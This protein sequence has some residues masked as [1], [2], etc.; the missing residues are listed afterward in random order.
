VIGVVLV[1][2]RS[3]TRKDSG[4]HSAEQAAESLPTLTFEQRYDETCYEI[5]KRRRGWTLASLS[6]DD[7]K[8]ILLIHV[9]QRYHKFNPNKVV[10]GR[11]VEYRHWLNRTVSNKLKNIL[12]DH[13]L[14]HARPCIQGCPF[15][16]GGESCTQTPSGRQCAE[17]NVFRGWEQKKRNHHV[18]AQTLPLENH[19]REVESV[20]SDFLDIA[21]AKK[22]LDQKIMERLTRHEREL[23]RLLYI[24]GMDERKVGEMF[25]YK[26]LSRMYA[27]YLVFL[28]LKHKVVRL[29]RKIIAEEGLA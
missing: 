1:R 8:Q 6:F 4:H 26:K 15:N 20:Q 29:A 2:K 7:V 18:I 12:R 3:R 17:C 11:R 13:Y 16:G 25:K 23:Y 10:N 21:G 5:E 14:C 28:D 19:S 9:H 24:K 22:V 27:G